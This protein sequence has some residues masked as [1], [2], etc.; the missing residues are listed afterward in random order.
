MYSTLDLEKAVK[1]ATEAHAGHYDRNGVPYIYHLFYVSA[2]QPT[3]EG[4]ILGLLHD[5]VEDGK[6]SLIDIHAKFNGSMALLVEDMS[7][8]DGESYSA[9]IDRVMQKEVTMRCKLTDIE[10]NTLVDR[11]DAKAAKKFPM[12]RDAYELICAKLGIPNSHFISTTPT[13]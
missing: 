11:M 6:M 2:A 3:I 4:K 1:Y 9:Y 12:Y 5:G 8:K 7:R 13:I 10:H